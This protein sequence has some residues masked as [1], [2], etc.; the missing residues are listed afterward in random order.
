LIRLLRELAEATEKSPRVEGQAHSFIEF[1]VATEEDNRR[2]A[3]LDEKLAG[4]VSARQAG[5]IA[6]HTRD[7]EKNLVALTEEAFSLVTNLFD[8]YIYTYEAGHLA[9]GA[10]RNA[11]GSTIPAQL[12]PR[13]NGLTYTAARLGQTLVIPD[14]TAHP[15]FAGTGWTGAIIGI[16]LKIGPRVVGVLTV[17]RRPAQEFTGDEIRVLQALADQ[18]AVEIENARIDALAGEQVRIDAATG[19]HNR[20]AFDDRL[21]IETL[22]AAEHQSP[23]SLF[24][25]D[26]EGI[27][28]VKKRY[29]RSA[30]DYLLAGIAT[31]AAQNLRKTDFIARYDESRWGLILS[32]ADRATAKTIAER[33]QDSVQRKRFSLPEPVLRSVSLSMGV[34]VFPDNGRSADL[35]I[36]SA[37]QAL[38]D[39]IASDPGSVRFAEAPTPSNP[40][41]P[42]T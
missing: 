10:A 24:L 11:E 17:C 5:E 16:P 25:I 7:L 42:T 1:R 23:F 37:G 3:G 33:I 38:S 27:R 30:A 15:L 26:I 8:A 6:G 34:A 21:Q 36:A 19:L 18:S 40:A 14:M 22:S 12:V 4:Q 13:P 31:A 35:L 32:R 28:E 41:A 9:Y 2:L 29:G 39:S 20:R